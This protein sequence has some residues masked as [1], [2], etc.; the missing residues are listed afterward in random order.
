MTPRH[1]TT[2]RD[3][4]Q[5]DTRVSLLQ[6][7][8]EEFARQGY[9]AA[10]INRISQSAGFAK[11][12]VYNYFAS[13]HELMLELISEIAEIHYQALAEPVKTESSPAKRLENFFRAG[14]AFVEHNY[15]QA[16]VM[17]TTIYGPHDDFKLHAYQAYQPLFELMG[18]DILAY[19][20]ARG[21]FKQME[22][23]STTNLLMI[24]YLGACSSVDAQGRY[25]L[26]PAQ[27]VNLAL[28][29]LRADK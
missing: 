7:A 24:I 29:G 8:A 3:Q 23:E 26:D 16:Q 12:T 14:F 19:G 6:A 27:L 4:I 18:Q 9:T 17:V 13:K 2:E 5:T 1:K 15:P 25:F 11:G 22:I 20:L 28:D 21:E 10:N